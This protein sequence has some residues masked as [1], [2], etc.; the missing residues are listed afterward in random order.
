MSPAAGL[1]H[2]VYPVADLCI[3]W[4]PDM[5]KW[6]FQL[7]ARPYSL[8]SSWLG[9]AS[10]SRSQQFMVI[11]TPVSHSLIL[12]ASKATLM[13]ISNSMH[14]HIYPHGMCAFQ[15]LSSSCYPDTRDPVTHNLMLRLCLY[16][17]TCSQNHHRLHTDDKQKKI[18]IQKSYASGQYSH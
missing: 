12:L 7:T 6:V 17:H 9:P 16:G 13:P 4:F 10:L 14:W 15:F 2:T 11:L 8:L 1:R 18:Y 3:L 5:C